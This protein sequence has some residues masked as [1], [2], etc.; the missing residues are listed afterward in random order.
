MARRTYIWLPVLALLAL[1]GAALAAETP[2]TVSPGNPSKLALI[3]DTCPAFSWAGGEGAQSYELVVYRVGEEGEEAEPVLRQN[4]PAPA[5]SWTPSLDRCLERGERYAW[6]VRAVGG[7]EASE[8]S[9]PSLFQVAARPSEA[10]F[11]EAV[12]VVRSYLAVEREGAESASTARESSAVAEPEGPATSGA[13][14]TRAAPA[15]TQ[16][17]VDGN[18]DAISFTGDGEN[19][20]NVATDAELATHTGLADAH[21]EHTTL[22]ESAEIDSDIATHAALADAH[23]PPTVDTFV[24]NRDGHDHPGG[25]GAAVRHSSLSGV[26][27]SDHHEQGTR[28][29]FAQTSGDSRNF[30]TTAGKLVHF[31]GFSTFAGSPSEIWIAEIGPAGQKATAFQILSSGNFL[32]SW[33]ATFAADD[34][35]PNIELLGFIAQDDDCDHGT[36]FT[37]GGPKR[38]TMATTDYFYAMSNSVLIGVTRDG[39]K[40]P[41]LVLKFLEVNPSVDNDARL[42]E[43]TITIGRVPLPS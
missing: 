24:T 39:P 37:F 28:L 40:I 15:G 8:W 5:Y 34:A 36:T 33:N 10:E 1:A 29:T 7:K 14:T 26:G 18:I 31:T 3:G 30:A 23:H 41:C 42:I 13:P 22:E 19:L 17:S 2:V 9:A 11:E 32:V 35:S 12:E 20:A 25:D 4:L 27:A 38:L 16:L 6:S 43:A 21:R